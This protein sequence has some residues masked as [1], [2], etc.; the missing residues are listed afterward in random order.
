[1]C[2]G[3]SIAG[4][5]FACP[6]P[7]KTKRYSFT[8]A[9][10]DPAINCYKYQWSRTIISGSSGQF[11]FVGRT[12][13]SFVDIRVSDNLHVKLTLTISI[14][15]GATCATQ[16][17]PIGNPFTFDIQSGFGGPI[18]ALDGVSA[19]QCGDKGLK[20]YTFSPSYIAGPQ[21]T[22]TAPPDWT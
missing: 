1:V 22:W 5:H 8:H 16:S 3:Q 15:S 14:K 21:I 2:F 6:D 20:T 17:A 13:T 10:F 4:D 7:S 19:V 18:K 11:S 9:P 12:D